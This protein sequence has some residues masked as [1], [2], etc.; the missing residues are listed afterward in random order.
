M[1]S[2]AAVAEEMAWLF[3]H[4]VEIVMNDNRHTLLALEVSDELGEYRIKV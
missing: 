1:A 4:P 3:M 2:K